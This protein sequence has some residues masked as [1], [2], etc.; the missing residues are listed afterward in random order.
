MGFCKHPSPDMSAPPYV[1]YYAGSGAG[2]RTFLFLHGLGTTGS[3]FA[4]DLVRLAPL[5][6]VL[7]WDMPG[8]GASPAL[9]PMTFATL[10]EAVVAVLDAEGVGKATLVGHS[11]GGMIA[12][13][14]V[15]RHPERVAGLVLYA[16]SAAFGGR[17]ETFKEKFLAER[18]APLGGDKSM[19]EIAPILTRDAF[20]PN[21]PPQAHRRAAA[22]MATIDVAAY[23]A[24]LKCLVT[25]NRLDN[26]ERIACPTLLLAAEH[27]RFVPPRTMERMAPRIP[28]AVYRCI[29]DAGHLANFERPI[30]FAEALDEFLAHIA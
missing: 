28:G 12:Q 27:D 13:E 4:D 8:Y 23:R 17:D 15:A 11:M 1:P 30:A 7:S 20:G 6:R 14:T 5:A 3:A 24:A 19:A 9:N 22:S 21:A 25:F 10:A 29:A 26:L 2:R 16:T 18:L